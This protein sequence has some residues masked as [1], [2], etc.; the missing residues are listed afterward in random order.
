MPR[1]LL[2]RA[3]GARNRAEGL[4]Q[5]IRNPPGRWRLVAFC[6]LVFLV[7][8]GF[9]GFVTHTIGTSTE[10]HPKAGA[11]A[12]LLGDRPFLATSGDRLRPRQP[13]VGRRIALTFDDGPDAK[14][15]PRIEAVLRREH[16]PG[17]FFVI[18][19]EAARHPDIV[20]R[21]AREGNELGNHTFTH[22]SLSDGPLWQRRQQL[23]LT[24]A[25]LV[26][27]TGQYTR[28]VR[29]P[30]SA[31]T[32]AI[33]PRQ[34]RELAKVAGRRYFIV[35]TDL[36]SE[37]WTRR[38]VGRILGRATPRGGHGGIIM[39]HDGGGDRSQTV[40]ALSKLIPSL[41]SRGFR[42]VTVSELA[43]LSPSVTHP[44]A[45]AADN[46]RGKA[47]AWSVR[48]AFALTAF[49][50]G[51]ILAVGVLVAVRALLLLALASHH[52]RSTRRVA[53]GAVE[54]LPSVSVIVPA[55]NEAVGIGSA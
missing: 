3:S 55:Y 27:I 4:S 25:I 11:P 39:F 21:V 22:T 51:L 2:L 14:W 36:D 43:G 31:T 26:G 33:D 8:I 23:S 1:R 18:G 16:V 12:P 40:V 32:D 44:G 29:P 7:V 42:F 15:T 47:F 9:Q 50:V 46:R 41:K 19:S 35:L 6:L 52:T 28:L 54:Y 34:E 30:Y 45:P 53:I 13:R 49:F 10:P 5:R 24:E 37:D 17:T 38:G 20:R 48:L